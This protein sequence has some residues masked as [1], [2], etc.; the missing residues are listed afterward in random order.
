MLADTI[1][2]KSLG[3]KTKN[4]EV[5]DLATGELFN[6]VEGSKMQDVEVFAGNNTHK[7]FRD[8]EKYAVR[9]GGA[10]KDWQHVKCIGLLDTP[11]GELRAKI[12]WVQCEN[13][14]KFEFFVKE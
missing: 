9:Y 14:G 8:A 4:Y 11:E 13:I 12:H 6:F 5:M 3:A 2:G 1:I 7:T 10:T